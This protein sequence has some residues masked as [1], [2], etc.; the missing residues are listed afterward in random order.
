MVLSP[1]RGLWA[2]SDGKWNGKGGWPSGAKCYGRRQKK[3]KNEKR[4]GE[5]K[6]AE[7]GMTCDA[8][9]GPRWLGY[10]GFGF[11]GET[12]FR[13]TKSNKNDSDFR[14]E[15]YSKVISHRSTFV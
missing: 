1:E 15:S 13:K 3:A 11:S 6:E 10:C 12:L 9:C 4:C 2:A 7:N 5:A 14:V 8:T